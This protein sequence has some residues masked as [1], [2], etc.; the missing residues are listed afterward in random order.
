VCC[1]FC[2]LINVQTEGRWRTALIDELE[3]L[4]TREDKTKYIRAMRIKCWGHLNR[5]MEITK[6]A[7]KITE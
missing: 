1:I 7:R 2:S 4:I 3:K 6:T 5:R